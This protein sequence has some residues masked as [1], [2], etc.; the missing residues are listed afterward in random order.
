MWGGP[1]DRIE[2]ELH[3]S[4][5]SIDARVSYRAPFAALTLQPLMR[6]D[7]PQVPGLGF[8]QFSIHHTRLALTLGRPTTVSVPESLSPDMLLSPAS[9]EV[10]TIAGQGKS[11][12]HRIFSGSPSKLYLHY[13]TAPT[14]RTMSRHIYWQKAG[15]RCPNSRWQM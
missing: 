11:N 3:A 12:G 15:R 7:Q 9:F 1:R 13:T 8:T 5:A 4:S 14:R 2:A 10:T 6:H